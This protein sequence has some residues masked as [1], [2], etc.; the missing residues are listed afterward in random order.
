MGPLLAGVRLPLG[1]NRIVASI[2]T[3]ES[4]LRNSSLG[5]GAS[6]RRSYEEDFVRT[7]KM[8]RDV[9]GTAGFAFAGYIFLNE[10]PDLRR[11]IRFGT[12]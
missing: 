1:R 3:P 7:V 12:M 10:I 8:L 2:H 9:L 5:S 6:K 11:Y 4:N